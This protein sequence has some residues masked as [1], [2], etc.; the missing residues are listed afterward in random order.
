VAQYTATHLPPY[1]KNHQLYKEGKLSEALQAA[2]LGFDESLTTEA[3]V[4]E[5]KSLAGV[6]DEDENEVEGIYLLYWF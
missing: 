1:I 4:N 2:F 6:G 3:V 5:L